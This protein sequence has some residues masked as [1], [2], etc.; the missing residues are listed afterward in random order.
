MPNWVGCVPM[1]LGI[2]E[3]DSSPTYTKIHIMSECVG[4]VLYIDVYV[5]WQV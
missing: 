2:S 1:P 3:S 5:G 4:H